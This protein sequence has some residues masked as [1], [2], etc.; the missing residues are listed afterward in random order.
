[1]YYKSIKSLIAKVLMQKK[2]KVKIKSK[3]SL[4]NKNLC[5]KELLYLFIKIHFKFCKKYNQIFHKF[6]NK[7]YFI[8]LFSDYNNK[9]YF[10]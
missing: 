5:K 2:I 4:F 3:K 6:A 8:I 9:N 10:S 1:M 7:R